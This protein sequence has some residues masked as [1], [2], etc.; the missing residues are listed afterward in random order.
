MKRLIKAFAIG[1]ALAAG[2]TAVPSSYAEGGCPAGMYPIQSPGVMGCAPFP[3]APGPRWVTKWGAVATDAENLG[4]HGVSNNEN[5]ERRARKL[6]MK[7][8]RR[9]GGKK[10]GISA[11]YAN[12]CYFSAMPHDG[13]GFVRGRRAFSWGGNADE[14]ETMALGQCESINGRTCRIE[15]SACALPVLVQ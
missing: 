7:N 4:P 9:G 10:C 1:G 6:A 13:Q 2:L 11:V 15:Y 14:A 3:Q 5:S 12:A 8:C